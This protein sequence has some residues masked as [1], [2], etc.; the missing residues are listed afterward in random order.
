M[1]KK[2]TM[3]GMLP[4]FFLLVFSF[5][6]C[7]MTDNSKIPVIFDT[8]ANNEVDDQHALAYL[9][10]NGDHFKVE[11]VTVNATRDRKSVV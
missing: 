3:T 9:L 1:N 7:S 4:V 10:F 8:D 2:F 6:A 5:S 11:G